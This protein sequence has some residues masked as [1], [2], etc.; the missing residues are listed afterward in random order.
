ML[1]VLACYSELDTVEGQLGDPRGFRSLR[2]A[3]GAF[4]HFP[5]FNL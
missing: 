4:I 5:I 1:Q 2:Q 3:V